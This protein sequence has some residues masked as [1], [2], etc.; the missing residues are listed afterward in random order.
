MMFRKAL[1]PALRQV[2]RKQIR[3][4]VRRPQPIKRMSTHNADHQ[5][6]PT[7]SPMPT[8]KG[9]NL[10][11]KAVSVLKIQFR[12]WY[13]PFVK[14]AGVAAI[15]WGA[16]NVYFH[17]SEAG[18]T[19]DMVDAFA[20]GVDGSVSEDAYIHE[21]G[22]NRSQLQRELEQIL[23]RRAKSYVV[24]VGEEGVGKSTV[25]RRTLA[26]LERPRGAIY[27][28][29]FS[30]GRIAFLQQLVKSTTYRHAFDLKACIRRVLAGITMKESDSTDYYD[31]LWSRLEEKLQDVGSAY[32][33]KYGRPPVLVVDGVDVLYNR[34]PQ[35]L[36]KLQT[37]A[38]KA[39]DNNSLRIVFVMSEKAAFDMLQSRPHA[40]RSETFV[41]GE[42]DDNEAVEFLVSRGVDETTAQDAVARITGGR[43]V[44]LNN[45]VAYHKQGLTN[46][47]VLANYYAATDCTLFDVGIER[48][49]KLF[50]E[51]S[52]GLLDDATATKLVGAEKI[53][54]LTREKILAV[55]PGTRLVTFNSR[56]VQTFFTDK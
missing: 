40:S 55:N 5:P 28:M 17:E 25:V 56:H 6:P 12:R 21:N 2:V 48:T 22:V 7:P 4:A 52:T 31:L 1:V 13:A 49:D 30:G 37:L 33:A 54:H 50:S 16:S 45:H 41:V 3:T 15:C 51:A 44:L 26:Q 18:V 39:A 11:P 32:F 14:F 10:D 29:P 38:E 23:R 27:V 36:T 53:A 34:N 20:E 42:V 46:D 8:I 35:F 43:F 19:Q 47:Q 24:I 9:G